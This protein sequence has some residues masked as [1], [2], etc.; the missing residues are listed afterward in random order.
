[1]ACTCVGGHTSKF[2]S[3]T[4]FDEFDNY[5]R[6]VLVLSL[7]KQSTFILLLA[8]LLD[9]AGCSIILVLFSSGAWCVHTTREW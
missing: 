2:K 1:M 7:P 6:Y 8:V 5:I 3:N 9:K 4:I